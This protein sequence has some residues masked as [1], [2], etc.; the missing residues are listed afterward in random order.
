MAIR[1]VVVTPER[2]EV[3]VDASYITLPMYD[4]E[5]GVAKGRA[6]MIGRLGHGLLKLD[7]D[8]GSRQ[9]FIDGGFAQVEGDSVSVLTSRA[10]PADKLD[11]TEA[12]TALE[13][14][15]NMPGGNVELTQLRDA[16][17]LRARGMVRAA[18]SRAR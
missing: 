2:T 17:L 14:A 13:A 12:E 16:A 5:L 8:G 18:R 1:C 3:D 6:A 15:N 7:I 4:G 10:I 9:W 11:L